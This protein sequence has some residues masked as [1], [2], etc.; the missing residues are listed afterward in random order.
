MTACDPELWSIVTLTLRVTLVALVIASVLGIPLG[1]WLGLARFPGKRLFVAL[2]Y[3]GMS[4][5]PVVVG[6]LVYMLLS[7][8]GP[9]AFLEWLF[10]PQAMIV[11]Q[12]VIALP[13]IAGLVMGAVAAVPGDLVG[14]IRSLGATPWQVR[15]AVLREARVGVLFAL[16]VAFGRIVSEVGAA[17]MVGGNIQGHTRVLSTA[18]MMETGK[19]DFALALALGGWL[20]VLALSVNL[21]AMRLQGRSL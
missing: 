15:W 10:T 12:T 14:Q 13:L 21:A 18:I 20:M 11:A 8:S 7:R 9:L 4:L 3:T 17:Y 6:L 5:P 2:V 1:V 16:L 19:G